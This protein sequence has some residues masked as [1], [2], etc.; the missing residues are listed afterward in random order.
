MRHEKA[1]P[2]Q[3]DGRF[4]YTSER[5][6][7][8]HAIGYCSA[9][10]ALESFERLGIHASEEYKRQLAENAEKFH[11]DGHE[12]AEE[13][14]E[15]YWQYLLD[16]R[17]QFHEQIEELHRCKVCSEWTGKSVSVDSRHWDLCD[18]HCNRDEVEKLMSP[19]GEAWVS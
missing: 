10:P 3:S 7:E 17:L 1:R 12:T 18:K 8:I 2:R 5:Q 16:F 9:A 14:C 11:T 4:D 19:I 13:A 6:G 15:C